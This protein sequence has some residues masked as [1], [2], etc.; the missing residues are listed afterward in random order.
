MPEMTLSVVGL[1]LAMLVL[2]FILGWIL[3]GGRIVREKAAINATWQ[4]QVDSEK[5]ERDRLAEQNKSL[6]E[7]IGQYRASK[8]DSDLRAKE[9]SEAL[10]EAFSR[11]DDLQRQLKDIRNNLEATVAQRNKA[12]ADVDSVALR[13]EAS[14]SALK[15]KDQKIFKLSRELESWRNRLPP[16]I[17]RFRLRDLEAQELEIELQ[18]A[19]EKVASL[20]KPVRPDE[21]RI[22]PM[23][24]NPLADGLDASNDQYDETTG[25]DLGGLNGGSGITSDTLT[26]IQEETDNELNI[27]LGEAGFEHV[28]RANETAGNDDH[29]PA[30]DDAFPAEAAVSALESGSG[31]YTAPGAAGE[32]SATTRDDLQRIKGV[33]PAI[34]KTLN[35]LGFYRF[36]QIAEMSEYDINRVANQLRGFRSRIYREDWIGQARLLQVE[37]PGSATT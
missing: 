15:E 26:G 37:H 33:G 16:L 29:S 3:R 30:A 6:M 17:E 34:E 20:E 27:D 10:K 21:T 19:Q 18:K 28:A 5:L 8:K 36:R 25:I 23:D 7:Q 11:R 35:S 12:R 9:L 13:S 31:R 22:E 14:Q 2:G 4:D 32:S 1:L 24:H